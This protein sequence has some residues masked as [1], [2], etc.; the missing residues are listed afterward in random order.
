[1]YQE[2]VTYNRLRR[3]TPDPLKEVT[4]VSERLLRLV[5]QLMRSGVTDHQQEMIDKA[6]EELDR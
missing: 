2:P 4:K 1:M 6:L 3:S 5:E